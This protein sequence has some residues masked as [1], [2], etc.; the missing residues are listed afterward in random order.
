M[1]IVN[2]KRE[3]EDLVFMSTLSNVRPVIGG[4]IT[5]KGVK[6]HISSIQFT[7]FNE[8]VSTIKSI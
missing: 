3:N 6:Y 5:I 7:N 8:V 4:Y 1:W 2:F